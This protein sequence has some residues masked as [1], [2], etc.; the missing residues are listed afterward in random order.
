MTDSDDMGRHIAQNS[1][2]NLI[3]I[4]NLM[5]IPLQYLLSVLF[6]L[7]LSLFSGL[8]VFDCHSWR[9]RFRIITSCP[10]RDKLFTVASLRQ[11]FLPYVSLCSVM[12]T[13]ERLL[14][15]FSSQYS[16]VHK[17]QRA[18]YTAVYVTVH[19]FA[20]TGN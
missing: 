19:Q 7:F 15:N 12:T 13:F 18:R 6:P 1:G 9:T 17:R 8:R 4:Q 5:R 10:L 3:V 16:T 14:L 11:S 20:H 2:S